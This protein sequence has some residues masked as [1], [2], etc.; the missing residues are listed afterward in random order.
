[1]FILA[2]YHSNL[3]G[4]FSSN[5]GYFKYTYVHLNL[6]NIV[7]MNVEEFDTKFDNNEEDI[8]DDLY[9]NMVS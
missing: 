3:A 1:M 9:K 7:D 4:F 5:S 2:D 8:V 6:I